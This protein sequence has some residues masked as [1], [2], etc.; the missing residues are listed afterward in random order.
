M[1]SRRQSILAF[2]LRS[3]THLRISS[4]DRGLDVVTASEYLAFVL[5]ACLDGS[6]PHRAGVPVGAELFAARVASERSSNTDVRF[7]RS[8]WSLDDPIDTSVVPESGPQRAPR[9]AAVRRAT[10]AASVARRSATSDPTAACV[11]SPDRP[12]VARKTDHGWAPSV[13]LASC[14]P[15]RANDG[16]RSPYTHVGRGLYPC[17]PSR[18]SHAVG[19]H[20]H[21]DSSK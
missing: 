3:P 7:C 1:G 2:L 12:R 13:R 20:T 15:R 18:C 4:P 9:C 17:R 19:G 14:C 6:N 8:W 21:D 5:P 11:A 16:S 10:S